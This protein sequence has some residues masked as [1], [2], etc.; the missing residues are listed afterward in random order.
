MICIL[1]LPLARAD[2]YTW[3]DASGTVNVSNLDPPAGVRVTNVIHASA[4]KTPQ[5][6]DAV[7]EAEVQALAER[8][9]LLEDELVMARRPPAPVVEYR[10]PPA[11]I[12]YAFDAVAAPAQYSFG[13]SQPPMTTACDASWM[14]CGPWAAPAVYPAGVVVLFATNARHFHPF[15]PG[16]HLASRPSMRASNG[17][18]MR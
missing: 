12:P 3:V 6:D 9:R 7:R 10:P 16:G 13:P 5:R 11:P 17:F 4:Q 18:Q 15:R 2:I 8:V 14:N 1:A